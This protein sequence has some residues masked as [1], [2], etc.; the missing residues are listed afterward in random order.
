MGEIREEVDILWVVI[1]SLTESTIIAIP[2]VITPVVQSTPPYGPRCFY[3]FKED[4]EM[5]PIARTKR[6]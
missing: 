1:Y 3:I 2:Q 5:V 6:G 4:E